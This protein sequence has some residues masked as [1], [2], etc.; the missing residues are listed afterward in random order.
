MRLGV[1][2]KFFFYNKNNTNED[3][4]I[5]FTSRIEK[6]CI[7]RQTL[8][9]SLINNDS[10]SIDLFYFAI[11]L[12]YRSGFIFNKEIIQLKTIEYFSAALT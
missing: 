9:R 6:K 12:S 7:P 3:R 2:I 1:Q 4:D 11:E 5:P 8:T 10:F